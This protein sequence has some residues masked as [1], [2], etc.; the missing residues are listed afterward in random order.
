MCFFTSTL[1]VEAVAHTCSVKKIIIEI[2]QNSQ[3]STC[4]RVSFLIKLQAYTFFY[5]TPLVATSEVFTVVFHSAYFPPKS[6]I[7]L[8]KKC[9][10]NSQSIDT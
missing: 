5:R 9:F 3:A 4:A 8:K 6:K 2:S 10:C 7:P 1:L